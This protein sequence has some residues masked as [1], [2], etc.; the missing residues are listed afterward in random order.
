MNTLI[1]K[2]NDAFKNG[3]NKWN[4]LTDAENDIQI[5]LYIGVKECDLQIFKVRGLHQN[6]GFNYGNKTNT[7]KAILEVLESAQKS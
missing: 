7:K 4:F 6:I 3:K 1:D 2:V 5:K